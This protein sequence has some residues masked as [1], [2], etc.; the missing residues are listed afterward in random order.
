MP[1]LIAQIDADVRRTREILPSTADRVPSARDIP[2]HTALGTT[3]QSAYG[4]PLRAVLRHLVLADGMVV[5]GAGRDGIDR[6]VGGADPLG[7]RFHEHAR[8]G[9]DAGSLCSA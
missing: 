8:Q 3:P 9:R 5:D 4:G 7:L 2:I 6:L 1:E